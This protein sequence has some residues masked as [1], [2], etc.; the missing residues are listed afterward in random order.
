MT[1]YHEIIPLF[2]TPLFSCIIDVDDNEREILKNTYMRSRPGGHISKSQYVLSETP[3]TK[4]KIITS[5]KT[6]IDELGYQF[7]VNLTTSWTNLH[8]FGGFGRHHSHANSMISGVLF[9]DT[10]PKSGDF[11]VYNPAVNGNRLFST[12]IQCEVKSPNNYNS[13]FYTFEPQT[14]QCIMFPSYL[15]HM[16]HENMVELPRWTVAFNFFASGTLRKDNVGEM[17]I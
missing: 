13:D 9:L 14:G 11:R 12:F 8:E 7:D 4:E 15:C 17:T 2:P 16:V 1:N 3:S 6:F 10:P 5:A